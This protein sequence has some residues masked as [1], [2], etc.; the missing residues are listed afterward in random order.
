MHDTFGGNTMIQAKEMPN[1][2]GTLL[3][4]PVDEIILASFSS[5]KL[6]GK[7]CR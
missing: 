5:I 1:F 2:M 6:I 3:Y 4:H 7:P